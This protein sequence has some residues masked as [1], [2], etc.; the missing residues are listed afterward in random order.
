MV[1]LMIRQ[2]MSSRKKLL[3]HEIIRA[4]GDRLQLQNNIDNKRVTLK[5]CVPS[6]LIPSVIWFFRFKRREVLLE[7]QST[8]NKKTSKP[9]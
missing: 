7:A 9:I 8:H 5:T 6:K 2:F 1:A 3:H 4:K